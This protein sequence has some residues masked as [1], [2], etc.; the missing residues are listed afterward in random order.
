[1][2]V[3]HQPFYPPLK[4]ALVLKILRPFRCSFSALPR[5]HLQN[6]RRH[7]TRSEIRV[8][9]DVAWMA[10]LVHWLEVLRMDGSDFHCNCSTSTATATRI[11]TMTK[12]SLDQGGLCAA[13]LH[14]RWQEG[15]VSHCGLTIPLPPFSLGLL[16]GK[17]Q[18]RSH[19]HP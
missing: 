2:A 11:H 7:D 6:A 3:L 1:M 17:G 18:R 8:A 16:E 9:V 4:K 15:T 5:P 14:A 10:L 19:T 12:V 13:Q